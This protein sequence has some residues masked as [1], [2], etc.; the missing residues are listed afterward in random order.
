MRPDGDHTGPRG[1]AKARP[2]HGRPVD[3]SVD[4]PGREAAP[5]ARVAASAIRDH[6]RRA[7]DAGDGEP[8]VRRSGRS[9]R[10]AVDERAARGRSGA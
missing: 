7:S 2:D 1:T 4:E 8:G 3:R 5:G 6:G 10:R 9:R